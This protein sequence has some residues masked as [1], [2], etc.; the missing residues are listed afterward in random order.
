MTGGGGEMAAAPG[1][2][3]TACIASGIFTVIA[4]QIG[5]LI[6]KNKVASKTYSNPHILSLTFIL[7]YK[8]LSWLRNTVNHRCIS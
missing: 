4:Q 7:R 8:Y 1:T 5:L 2:T 6:R 3:I